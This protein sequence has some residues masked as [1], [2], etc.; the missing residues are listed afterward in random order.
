MTTQT[1][2]KHMH[3]SSGT[4]TYD[5]SIRAREDSSCLRPRSSVIGSLKACFS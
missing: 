4:R 5:P 3:A 2:N 1:Q